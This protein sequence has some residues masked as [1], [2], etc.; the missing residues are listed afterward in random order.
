MDLN[1]RDP[2]GV[3]AAA[4]SLQGKLDHLGM[5]SGSGVSDARRPIS[6]GTVPLNVLSNIRGTARSGYPAPCNLSYTHRG[7]QRD[8]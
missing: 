2:M 3:L 4:S 1:S 8:S 7:Q 6:D 5:N